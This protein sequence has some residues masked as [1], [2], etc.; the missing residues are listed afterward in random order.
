[1]RPSHV[2]TTRR[3]FVIAAAGSGL[4]V[5][6]LRPAAATPASMKAAIDA[7]AGGAVLREGRVM[8]DVPRLVDNG[9]LVS[10]TV[11]VDSPMTAADHVRE[12][13]IFN[14][15]NPLPDVVRFQLSPRNGRAEVATGIRLATTQQLVAAA[16]TSDGSV[17]H[18]R[19]E[20]LVALAA[21]IE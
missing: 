4:W 10:V 1:M 12:I 15:G 21:C 2:P 8:L 13:A 9:N 7:W 20:V 18:Q 16:K 19:V 3:G 17:W 11:R 6:T 14:E 5:A